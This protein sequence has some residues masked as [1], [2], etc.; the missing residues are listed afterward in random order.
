[1][2][3]V[4]R[5]HEPRPGEIDGYLSYLLREWQSIPE[6]AAEWHEW[7]QHSRFSFVIDWPICEDRLHMLRT[8][9]EQGKMTPTQCDRYHELLTLVNEHRPTL[10]RLLADET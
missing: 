8:W 4:A 6:L 1:M 3:R 10:E 7:D 9:A 2:A 5:L